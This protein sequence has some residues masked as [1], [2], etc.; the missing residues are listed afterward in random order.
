MF[1]E[2]KNKA[3]VMNNFI[4]VDFINEKKNEKLGFNKFKNKKLLVFVGRLD[5][6]SKKI[7]KAKSTCARLKES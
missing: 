3:L 5:E 4:N 1:P 6:K 2:H 7:S